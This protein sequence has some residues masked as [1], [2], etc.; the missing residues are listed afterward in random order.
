MPD[1]AARFQYC[2]QPPTQSDCASSNPSFVFQPGSSTHLSLWTF[3]S[4]NDPDAFGNG[5]TW[6]HQCCAGSPATHGSVATSAPAAVSWPSMDMQL[7]LRRLITWKAPSDCCTDNHCWLDTSLHDH[8]CTCEI[9]LSASWSRTS[10]HLPLHLLE[11]CHQPAASAW[12]TVSTISTAT[13][14]AVT[15]PRPL[16]RDIL[17]ILSSRRSGF[18]A[19]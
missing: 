17:T 12:A 7:P 14:D 6:N 18:T 3:F 16:S 9:R 8:C 11:M 15:S 19:R 5:L 1:Q 4:Q 13:N 2:F 10:M